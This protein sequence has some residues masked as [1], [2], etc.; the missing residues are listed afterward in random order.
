MDWTQKTLMRLFRPNSV[1]APDYC[2]ELFLCRV[3]EVSR[4]EI[5]VTAQKFV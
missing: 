4:L 5:G 3:A 2:V 1:V